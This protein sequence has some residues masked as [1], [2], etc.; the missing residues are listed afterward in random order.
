[1]SLRGMV[2]DKL[3]K[4]RVWRDFNQMKGGISVTPR[5]DIECVVDLAFLVFLVW[6]EKWC[7][8]NGY[9]W[10]GDNLQKD[11]GLVHLGGIKPKPVFVKIDELISAFRKEVDKK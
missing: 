9:R 11:C 3:A 4:G 8:D 5:Q 2:L 7:D 10:V 6:L 1:M